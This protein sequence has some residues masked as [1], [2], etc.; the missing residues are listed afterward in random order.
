[1]RETIRLNCQLFV[2]YSIWSSS[3]SYSPSLTSDSPMVDLSLKFSWSK[4]TIPMNAALSKYSMHTCSWPMVFPHFLINQSVPNGYISNTGGHPYSYAIQMLAWQ[5]GS[6]CN[7]F[8]QLWASPSCDQQSCAF[9]DVEPGDHHL[10]LV[11]MLSIWWSVRAISVA[12]TACH[13]L[14]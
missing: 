1:M 3:L 8:T 5:V 10:S 6:L 9:G 11:S 13:L 4:G 12:D 7:G 14:Y 2:V